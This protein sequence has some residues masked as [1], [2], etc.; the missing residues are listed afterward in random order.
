MLRGTMK[1]SMVMKLQVTTSI[2]I[3]QEAY[4]NQDLPALLSQSA[5]TD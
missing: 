2:F 5:V 4:A 3:D 1:S